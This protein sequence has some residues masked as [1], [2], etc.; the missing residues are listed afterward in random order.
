MRSCSLLHVPHQDKRK[1]E[2]AVLSLYDQKLVSGFSIVRASLLMDGES[3]YD[4]VRAG[5]VGR[6]ADSRWNTVDGP[7]VGY[8]IRRKDVG[9][10]IFNEILS[11]KDPGEWLNQHVVVSY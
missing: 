8:T 7:A 10:F 2:A 1:M 6:K 9:R 3:A 5:Y 4:S 11:K